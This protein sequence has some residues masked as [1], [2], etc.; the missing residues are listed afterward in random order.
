MSSLTMGAKSQ[1]ALPFLYGIYKLGLQGKTS[2]KLKFTLLCEYILKNTS[3]NKSHPFP[4]TYKAWKRGNVL[5]EPRTGLLEALS[6]VKCHVRVRR[7]RLV[8]MQGDQR[9]DL[10][11]SKSRVWEGTFTGRE[12]QLELAASQS[13]TSN[14][15]VILRS[16]NVLEP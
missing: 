13:E 10:Q 1:S 2:F 14:E 11:H 3:A 12:P 15:K 7:A 9:M 4:C 5:F 6:W 16:F 8:S